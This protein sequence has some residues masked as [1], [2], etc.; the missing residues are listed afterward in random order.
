M[1]LPILS[2]YIWEVWGYRWVFLLAGAI[3]LA[4]FFICL[5]IKV[6]ATAEVALEPGKSS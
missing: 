1:S 4:G 6:P 5:Q 2:G 3:A